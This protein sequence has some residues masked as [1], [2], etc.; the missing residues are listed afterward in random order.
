MLVTD[1][2]GQTGQKRRAGSDAQV[3]AA[4]EVRFIGEPIALVAAESEV[5]AE[6]ALKLIEVEYEPLHAVFDPIEAMQ[7]GAPQL[8]PPDNIVAHWKIRK[9]DVQ[10]GWQRPI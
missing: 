1:M 9:G 7:P 5:L 6:Q 4:E 2:P 8:Y 10:A 3:L